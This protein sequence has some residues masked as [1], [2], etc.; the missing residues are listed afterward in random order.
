MSD[1]PPPSPQK[2]QTRASRSGALLLFRENALRTPISSAFYYEPIRIASIWSW[3]YIWAALICILAGLWWAFYGTVPSKIA[4]QGA[5]VPEGGDLQQIRAD[6][7]G[8]IVKVVIRPG[9]VVNQ[10]AILA[11]LD[12][13]PEG[14]TLRAEEDTAIRSPR[15]GRIVAVNMRR[16]AQIESG[17][18]VAT[19]VG[20]R[21]Q[22][23]AVVFVDAQYAA[24]LTPGTPVEAIPGTLKRERFGAITG[25]VQEVGVIPQTMASLVAKATN[26]PSGTSALG[27]APVWVRIKLDSDPNSATGL[28]WTSGAGPTQQ[29]V[30]P[31]TYGTMISAHFITRK[32]A[33]IELLFPAMKR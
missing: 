22:I 27:S 14:I 20:L 12:R 8:T 31:L 25:S 19:T 10:G 17:T 21:N 33:P 13:P 9:D 26:T 29:Q 23:E 24:L 18:Q 4:A 30:G 5:L 15:A 16:G 3:A 28:R 32:E 11:Y 7:A 6:R 2:P 1:A